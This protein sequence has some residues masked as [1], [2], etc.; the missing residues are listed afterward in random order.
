MPVIVKHFTLMLGG[1]D[2]TNVKA[3]E[4]ITLTLEKRLGAGSPPVR[5]FGDNT[6]GRFPVLTGLVPEGPTE[7]LTRHNG[8][9]F[10]RLKPGEAVQFQRLALDAI[11]SL[12]STLARNLQ[13]GTVADG[14]LAKVIRILEVVVSHQPLIDLRHSRKAP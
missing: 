1:S 13:G 3:E 8:V 5:R 11:N 6:A 14:I 4:I 7:G 12:C 10:V 9:G 2:P